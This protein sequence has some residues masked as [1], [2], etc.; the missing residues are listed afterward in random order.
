MLALLVEQEAIR[1][2]NQARSSM[3]HCMQAGLAQSVQRADKA[4]EGEHT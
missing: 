2:A 3:F 4:G 1:M